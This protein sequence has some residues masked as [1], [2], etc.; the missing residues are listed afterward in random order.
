MKQMFISLLLVIPLG[1]GCSQNTAH[2]LVFLQDDGRGQCRGRTGVTVC[3]KPFPD[4]TEEEKEEF[5]RHVT[6]SLL[7]PESAEMCIASSETGSNFGL[8]DNVGFRAVGFVTGTNVIARIF[9]SKT[10]ERKGNIVLEVDDHIGDAPPTRILGRTCEPDD[11]YSA[12][13]TMPPN[14]Y[15]FSITYTVSAF[16][17]D[18]AGNKT[19]P[20]ATMIVTHP[21]FTLP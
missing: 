4:L 13:Y 7:L 12:C 9:G 11:P 21:R 14:S 6:E 18:V 17:E 5:Q 20:V 8:C 19:S 3:L 1:L 15:G 2:V 10:Y 16:T